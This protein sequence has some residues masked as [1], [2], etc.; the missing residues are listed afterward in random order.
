MLARGLATGYAPV[1]DLRKFDGPIKDQG[2]EGACTGHAF[3]E[4]AETIFRMYPFWLPKGAPR[5]PVFSP[6]WFYEHELIADG[7]F[8]NDNGSNGETGCNVAVQYGFCP[9]VLD[10]YVAGQITKPT[11][12]QDAAARPYMMG[13]YHGLQGSLSA[14]SVLGDKTPWP[15]QLGFTVYESF[16]SEAV[17]K[18]GVYNPDPSTESVLGGHEV[19]LSGYDIGPTPTLRPPDCPPA[20][21][22]QNSWGA[23]WGI[24]GYF[25]AALSVLDASDTDLKLIHSGHPWK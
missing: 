17:A 15:V 11:A 10:P 7:D 23:G 20:V 1:V 19:K 8:P 12:E 18:T 9:L 21:L 24:G 14:I 6:Q 4:S 25:W 16:E 22:V 5:D 3:A 13:A 2:D